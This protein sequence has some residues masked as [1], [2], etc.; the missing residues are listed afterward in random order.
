MILVEHYEFEVAEDEEGDSIA[1]CELFPQLCGIGDDTE[2]AA[3]A[4]AAE[5]ADYMRNVVTH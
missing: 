3:D 4:L 5:I 2:E 1:T